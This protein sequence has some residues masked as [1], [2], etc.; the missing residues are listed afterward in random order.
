[1]MVRMLEARRIAIVGANGLGIKVGTGHEM[2]GLGNRGPMLMG[3]MMLTL[4]G[5][6]SL[7]TRHTYTSHA[8]PAPEAGAPP[9]GGAF[10]G[11]LGP[12]HGDDAAPMCTTG[13]ASCTRRGTPVTVRCFKQPRLEGVASFGLG[14]SGFAATL[15]RATPRRRAFIEAEIAVRLS[16]PTRLGTEA[17]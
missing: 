15:G 11:S 14:P 10:G 5:P 8:V 7:G 13:R 9:T 2:S 16:R 12:T 1:M 6:S 17:R 4:A 3:R